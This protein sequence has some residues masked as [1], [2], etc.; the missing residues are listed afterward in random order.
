MLDCNALEFKSNFA[1]EVSVRLGLI[2]P[3]HSVILKGQNIVI[4]RDHYP[5]K[6]TLFIIYTEKNNLKTA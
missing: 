2:V 6:S 3:F 1:N 5:T 4:I